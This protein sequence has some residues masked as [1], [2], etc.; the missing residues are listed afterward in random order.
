VTDT[1]E[2][3]AA[4]SW[5]VS[6]PPDAPPI[7]FLHGAIL[8]RT[9]WRPVVARLRARYRCITV[10]LPGHGTAAADAFSIQAA[11]DVVED[12]IA[13]YASGRAVLVGL[14]L[15]GF[16]AMAVAARSPSLVRGLVLAGATGEPRGLGRLAVLAFGLL[17]QLYPEWLIRGV[18]EG[19][20]RRRWGPT[21]AAEVLS[22]GYHAVSGG[23]S[24]RVLAGER[25]RDRLLA[26]GGPI[27]VINGDQDL[28][29]RLTEPQFIAGIPRLTAHRLAGA[30]HLSSV[31]RPAEFAAEID[32][33]ATALEA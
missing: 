25:F 4:L 22:G 11:A 27:L 1:T 20:M 17:L 16:V 10:D 6:G 33:F 18:D 14:S 32:A 13:R 24:I 29:F 3:A 12:V 30:A 7:V 9:M 8:T 23:S 2:P 15:G 28:V 26:Y 21:L 19:I 31:D 5:E